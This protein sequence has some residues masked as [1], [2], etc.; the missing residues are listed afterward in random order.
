MQEPS[1]GGA[2][3]ADGALFRSATTP[4]WTFPAAFIAEPA[5]FGDVPVQGMFAQCA[6]RTT[7]SATGIRVYS[8]VSNGADITHTIRAEGRWF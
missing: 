7:T 2:T 6:A 1:P 8:K 4:N 3:T 5:V